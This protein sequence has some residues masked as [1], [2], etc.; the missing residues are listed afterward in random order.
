MSTN[1]YYGY[2]LP[3]KDFYGITNDWNECEKIVKRKNGA[4]FKRFKTRAEANEWINKGAKYSYKPHKHLEKGIYFDSGTARGNVEVSV[5]DRERKNLLDKI[6]NKK[7]INKFGKHWVFD[8]EATNN[9]GELY[10]CYLALE[11]AIKTGDKNIFGDSNLVIQYW[12]K[13]IIKKNNV[14]LETYNLALETTKLREKFKS[15]G[16]TVKFISGDDN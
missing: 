10:A 15:L 13:G 1:K 11:I 4:R 3:E 2:F 8:K 9:F 14:P 7:Y 12:S 5:T 6:L 16:G